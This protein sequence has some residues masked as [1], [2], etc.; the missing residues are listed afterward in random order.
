MKYN[1]KLRN[2]SKLKRSKETGQKVNAISNYEFSWYKRHYL[3]NCQNLS[4]VFKSEDNIT[5]ILIF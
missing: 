2:S 3:T 5:S 1:E 4:K